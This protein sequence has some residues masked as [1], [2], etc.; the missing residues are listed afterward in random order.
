MKKLKLLTTIALV[1]GALAAPAHAETE[2]QVVV[3]NLD[4]IQGGSSNREKVIVGESNVDRPP[5]HTV[6]K[7]GIGAGYGMKSQSMVDFAGLADAAPADDNEVHS[8]NFPYDG[9][10]KTHDDFGVFHFAQV[11]ANDVW[12]GEWSQTAAVKDQ[13]NT[14]YYVGDNADDRITRTDSAATYTVTGINNYTTAANNGLSG[15]FTANFRVLTLTGSMRTANL[16]SGILINIGTAH[17]NPKSAL[18]ATSANGTDAASVKIILDGAIS[19]WFGDAN[20][21]VLGQFYNGQ[22]NLAGMVTFADNPVFDTAFGGSRD[23]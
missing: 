11:G 21:R 3:F 12:F 1:T 18:I 7:A 23:Q 6:G 14:V 16:P 4:E 10:P 15:T 13:T 2:T 22:A 17:I 9:A 8:L 5:S 19:P 20:G